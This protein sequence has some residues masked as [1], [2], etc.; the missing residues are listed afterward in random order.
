MPGYQ[1]TFSRI[2][3]IVVLIVTLVT[4]LMGQLVLMPVGVL[5]LLIAIAMLVP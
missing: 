5:F 4:L 2:L 1:L 3:G